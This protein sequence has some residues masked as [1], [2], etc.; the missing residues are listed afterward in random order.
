MKPAGNRGHG[1]AASAGV[2]CRCNDRDA[3]K[4]YSKASM[5][6]CNMHADLEQPWCGARR[7]DLL[8]P[9][10]LILQHSQC[11][12]GSIMSFECSVQYR[13]LI[14][15][16]CLWGRD[17][18]WGHHIAPYCSAAV[19]APSLGALVERSISGPAIPSIYRLH[20]EARGW[21]GTAQFCECVGL[22]RV[23]VPSPIG[24]R[25]VW[26]DAVRAIGVWGAAL[27]KPRK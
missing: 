6:L 2:V 8:L 20:Q 15:G 24:R 26:V 19:G 1:P 13:L 18:T 4:W 11:R 25:N 17:D 16:R 21:L 12:D 10:W 5:T 9:T 22:V 3:S 23:P 7:P 27:V 14:T